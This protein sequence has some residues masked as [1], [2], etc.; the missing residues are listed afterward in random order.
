MY[1]LF[2]HFTLL[3]SLQALQVALTAPKHAGALLS[4]GAVV[5]LLLAYPLK[6]SGQTQYQKI[7]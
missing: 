5:A 1:L 2:L 6:A 4:Q 3:L 7:Y